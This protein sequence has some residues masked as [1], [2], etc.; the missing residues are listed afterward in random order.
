MVQKS[1]EK[2]Q[3]GQLVYFP[4]DNMIGMITNILDTQHIMDSKYVVEWFIDGR[5][6]EGYLTELMA[7]KRRQDYL[8]IIL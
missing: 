8:N 3:K 4:L 1:G 7:I 2:L 5:I 6:V